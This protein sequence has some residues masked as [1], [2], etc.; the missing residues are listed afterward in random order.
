MECFVKCDY[1]NYVVAFTRYLVLNF[2]Y[3]NHVLVYIQ[4]II[5]S[6]HEVKLQGV[7]EADNIDSELFALKYHWATE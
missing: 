3:Y 1:N 2:S 7:L 4:F 6:H 5:I